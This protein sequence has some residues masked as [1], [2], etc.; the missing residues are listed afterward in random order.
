[1]S[2]L[3]NFHILLAEA[4]PDLG[5]PSKKVTDNA[6]NNVANSGVFESAFIVMLGI[7]VATT[8]WLLVA[9]ALKERRH[10]KSMEEKD[11]LQADTMRE[12]IEAMVKLHKEERETERADWKLRFEKYG[13]LLTTAGTD[14]KDSQEARIGLAGET[15]AV[16]KESAHQ[17]EKLIDTLRDA[18]DADD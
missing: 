15:V 4:T 14:L 13:N 11:K 16:Q 18:L 1:M 5:G 2:W 7:F 10:A 12:T 9:N 17:M 3:L 8:A 6:A